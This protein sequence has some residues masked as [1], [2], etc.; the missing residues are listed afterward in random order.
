ML[1]PPSL[2]I[3]EDCLYTRTQ[4]ILARVCYIVGGIVVHVEEYGGLAVLQS[5]LDENG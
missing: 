2:V 3:G 1:L 5:A 4:T